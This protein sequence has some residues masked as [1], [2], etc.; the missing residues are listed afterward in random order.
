MAKSKKELQLNAEMFLALSRK[1]K[2]TFKELVARGVDLLATDPESGWGVLHFVCYTGDAKLLSE[3]LQNDKLKVDA[4]NV[5]GSTPLIIASSR[6]H[7][8]CVSLL[9]D[10]KASVNRQD[11]LGQ[12][13]LL[14]AVDIGN[15]KIIELLLKSGADLTIKYIDREA[16][17]VERSAEL[18]EEFGENL[19]T[20]FNIMELTL[21]KAKWF[22]KNNNQKRANLYREVLAYLEQ[23]YLDKNLLAADFGAAA[24][25]L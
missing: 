15:M 22:E 7:E 4:L 8:D 5:D 20:S 16:K 21:Q 3:L 19:C 23:I 9:I 12:T 2:K 10:K 25:K 24:N 14:G 1:D 18:K 6:G 17:S 11:S 13:A